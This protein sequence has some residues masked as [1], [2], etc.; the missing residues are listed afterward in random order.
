MIEK[1]SIKYAYF[2]EGVSRKFTLRKNTCSKGVVS[3]GKTVRLEP[4]RYM[5]GQVR[6]YNRSG[7]GTV[8]K[9]VMFLRFNPVTAA[10]TAD[11]QAVRVG[12][13]AASRRVSAWM[14]DLTQI[15][16]ILNAWKDDSVKKRGNVYKEGYTMRGWLF[17]IA[18]ANN[19]PEQFPAN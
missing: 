13:T 2:I 4:T 11:Q 16:T 12:F 18:M 8:Q 15:P 10:I 19:S 14:N 7:L 3:L 17:A 6:T 1:S 5:G 9:N